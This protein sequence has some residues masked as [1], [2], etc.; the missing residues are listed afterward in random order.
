MVSQVVFELNID[1]VHVPFSIHTSVG[2]EFVTC[3]L[4]PPVRDP[5]PVLATGTGTMLRH[6]LDRLRAALFLPS[7]APLQ[8]HKAVDCRWYLMDVSTVPLWATA[9]DFRRRKIKFSTPYTVQVKRQ[10]TLEGAEHQ[11]VG[12]YAVELV[13]RKVVKTLTDTVDLL[14]ARQDPKTDPKQ[15]LTSYDVMEKGL[16]TKSCRK[17][18]LS[19]GMLY[20]A[21]V[22]LDTRLIEVKRNPDLT[23]AGKDA[24]QVH[25]DELR[26][27]Q[28]QEA[29]RIALAEEKDGIKRKARDPAELLELKKQQREER[30]REAARRAELGKEGA[31]KGPLAKFKRAGAA[32]ILGAKF[33]KKPIEGKE[34]VGEDPKMQRKKTLPNQRFKRAVAISANSK[35]SKN[36]SKL[37]KTGSS[38]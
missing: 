16:V 33:G 32:A 2:G 18:G 38:P 12:D 7:D 24:K 31:A 13:A 35:R 28:L 11:L 4:L 29:A 26:H 19:M 1:A 15:R 30:E 14:V 8:I 27:L 37:T 20:H 6:I 25:L 3:T 22:Q 17:H 34:E 21:L 9:N 5:M 10:F 23:R 36:R